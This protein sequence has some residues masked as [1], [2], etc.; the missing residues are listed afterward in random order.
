MDGL[1]LSDIKDASLGLLKNTVQ[2]YF[3]CYY[4]IA[5]GIPNA[6]VLWGKVSKDQDKYIA[7]VY[8]LPG[9]KVTDP[10]KMHKNEAITL[11][12]FWRACLDKDKQLVFAFSQWRGSN[13]TLQEPMDIDSAD[14][15]QQVPMKKLKSRQW[16]IV[17]EKDWAPMAQG[18]AND[19]EGSDWPIEWSESDA[20]KLDRGHSGQRNKGK[21]K[22]NGWPMVRLAAGHAESSK[23]RTHPKPTLKGR[24][25]KPMDAKG[26]SSSK[27]ARMPG[28]ELEEAAE[29]DALQ[30]AK[31]ARKDFSER[32]WHATTPFP[33]ANDVPSSEET[34]KSTLTVVPPSFNNT[35]VVSIYDEVGRMRDDKWE[36]ANE[37]F[38]ANCL[39]PGN[40][41][42]T[43]E[44]LP[45]QDESPG[46]PPLTDCDS[47]AK[48]RAGIGKRLGVDVQRRGFD[49]LYGEPRLDYLSPP[50]EVTSNVLVWVLLF[51]WG[52][53]AGA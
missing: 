7:L 45:S 21:A 19:S 9:F 46:P 53:C 15:A 26:S 17:A 11:L 24:A 47:D 41:S 2:G 39:G 10:S 36:S 42:V 44:C 37:E 13:G 4:R 5:C 33:D 3:T 20:P 25:V 48:A 28:R 43:A 31:K 34:C 16:A 30:P 35:G 38:K 14:N 27:R 40:V 22:R 51:E 23:A 52:F 29:V 1:W 32:C 49:D 12:E 18:A 8:L 6:T 50:H